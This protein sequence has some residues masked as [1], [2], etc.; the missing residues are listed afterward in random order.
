MMKV[1]DSEIVTLN[2]LHDFMSQRGSTRALVY[3]R[4]Y[5][6]RDLPDARRCAAD[7]VQEYQA[8]VR[9]TMKLFDEGWVHLT[10]RKLGFF[11]YE[12]RVQHRRRRR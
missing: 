7:G 8:V 6:A 2:E 10:Q 12:Y 9:E 3:V 1:G 4:G 5:I 11:L